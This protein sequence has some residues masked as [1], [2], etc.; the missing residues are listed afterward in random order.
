MGWDF[1]AYAAVSE[2]LTHRDKVSTL[3]GIVSF[4][5][6]AGRQPVLQIGLRPPE[7]NC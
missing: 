3:H 1:S 5:V 2:P 4:T 7:E 6:A